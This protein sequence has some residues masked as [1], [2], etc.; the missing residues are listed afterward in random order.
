MLSSLAAVVLAACNGTAVVTLTSTP[1]QDTFLAYRVSLVSLDLT[2]SSG[3]STLQ[4][5]PAAASVDLATL[6]NLSEVLGAAAVTKGRYTSAVL[7]LDYTTA[8]IVYDDGSANGVTLTAVDSSGKALT[9]VRLTVSLDPSDSFSI[10]ARTAAHLALDFNL[11]ASNA[12]DLAAKTVTVT[13]LIAASVLPIDAKTVRVRGPLVGV[14][15]STTSATTGGGALTMGIA[16]FN[17]PAGLGSL[18]VATADTTTYEVNGTVGVGSAGL[19]LLSERSAGTMTVAYGTLTASD[20]TTTTST[21]GVATTT[22]DGSSAVTGS[23]LTFTAT[24]VLGGSSVQ[25]AGLDRITGV[26]SGRSNNVIALQDATLLAADGTETFL[27]GSAIISMGSG[28]SV[29]ALGQSATEFG[30]TLSVSVGSTIDAFGVVTALSTENA[31]M[32]VSAGRVRIDSTTASG[33]V[34]AQDSGLIELNLQSLGGRAVAGFDFTGS[35]AAPASYAVNSGDLDLTNAV[36]GAPVVVSGVT[37][38]FG[39]SPP[40]FIASSLLDPTTLEAQLVVDW[41]AGTA[42]PFTSYDSTAIDLDVHNSSIGTRHQIT[43]GALSVNLAGLASDPLIEPDSTASNVLFAIGHAASASIESFDTYA[44][45]IAQLQTEL[46]GTKALG[47]TAGGVYSASSLT[48][49]AT[50]ITVLLAN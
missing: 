31:A 45:F 36:V 19:S 4:V 47:F 8:Q 43:Q 28:T 5:L 38:A 24:Q 22:S 7:T 18:T 49:T 2:P 37:N 25:G 29:T 14:S 35:A 21:D 10:A 12:I 15:T 44:A 50:R 16:P 20:Q 11:A 30:S 33:L 42:T 6:T 9:Q 26:V 27:P 41:G 1:S 39:V 40:N 32:D 3:S 23:T 17:A 34:T 48:L 46:S 13:P